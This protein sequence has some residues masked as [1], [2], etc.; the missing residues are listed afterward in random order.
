MNRVDTRKSCIIEEFFFV[1]YPHNDVIAIRQ[2]AEKQSYIKYGIRTSIVSL[3]LLFICSISLIAQN[4]I[5]P[6]Y[7]FKANDIQGDAFDF[8]SL[9]GKKIIIINTATKC[10]FAPQLGELQEL[11]ESYKDKGLAIVAFPCNDFANREPKGNS[12][13][14]KV[15]TK[16]YGM[17]YPLMSKISVK[18]EAMHP[19]YQYLTSKELN[20]YSDNKVEWNF[21]KYLI[22]EKGYLEMIIHPRKSPMC[23]EIMEWIQK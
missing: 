4:E 5:K 15:C 21:Q 10:M 2:Q 1:H 11:Y 18:D 17:T 19:I 20:G 23:D 9:K 16:K 6:I 22:N 3:I 14:R 8:S 12:T 13:I 7:Q